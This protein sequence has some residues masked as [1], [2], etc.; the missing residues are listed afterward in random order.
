M[1]LF[2]DIYDKFTT[3]FT[4]AT[5]SNL[6]QPTLEELFDYWRSHSDSIHVKEI[7]KDLQDID[8]VLK[9][10]NETLTSEE[11]WLVSYGMRLNWLDWKIHDEDALKVSIS[12]RDYTITSRANM[13]SALKNMK[14]QTQ[15]DLMLARQRYDNYE[16]I[17]EVF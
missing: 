11:Q 2:A 6:T 5:L 13:L 12:D 14:T 9:Q 17:I 4:D 10:Y 8:I 7:R 16:D 15:S 1:T 3:M